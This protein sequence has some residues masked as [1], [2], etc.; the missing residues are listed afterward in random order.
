MTPT[1]QQAF[2][3]RQSPQQLAKFKS[4]LGNLVRAGVIQ[5]PGQ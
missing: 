4:D 5:L 3:K 1:Q 2:I